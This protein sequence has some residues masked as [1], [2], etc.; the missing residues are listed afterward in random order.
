VIAVRVRDDGTRND[1]PRVDVEVAL[2]TVKT[3]DSL[4]EHR[5]V[6][7]RSIIGV[8]RQSR[9]TVIVLQALGGLANGLL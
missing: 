7:A 9:F 2:G 1:L 6:G 3:G 5:S 4:D 8:R